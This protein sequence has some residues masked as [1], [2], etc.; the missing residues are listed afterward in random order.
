MLGLAVPRCPAH[1][2]VNHVQGCAHGCRY[3]C[4]ASVMAR[5]YGRAKDEAD[6]RRPRLVENAVELLEREL[7]RERDLID[8]VHLCL[9]TDPL[10]WATWRSPPSRSPSSSV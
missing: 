1:W 2:C 3:P 7:A 6:W 8:V 4:Y 5:R 10:W 9:T